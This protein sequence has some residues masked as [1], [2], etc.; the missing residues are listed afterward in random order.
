MLCEVGETQR[1]RVK[2]HRFTRVELYVR[3][4]CIA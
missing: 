3:N 4:V 1:V 2:R